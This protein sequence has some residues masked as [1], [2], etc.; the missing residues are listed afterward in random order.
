MQVNVMLPPGK[1]ILEVPGMF[2][3]YA[4]MSKMGIPLT[5]MQQDLWDEAMGLKEVDPRY[6]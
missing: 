2:A 1:S 5:K 3:A 6:Q 4:C